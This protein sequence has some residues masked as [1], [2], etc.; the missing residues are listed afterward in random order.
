MKADRDLMKDRKKEEKEMKSCVYA[1]QAC[2][3]TTNIYF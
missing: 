3:W 1:K 2:L